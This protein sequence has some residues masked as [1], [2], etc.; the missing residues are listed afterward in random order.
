MNRDGLYL[1]HIG[2]CIDK[3]EQ[4]TAGGRPNSSGTQ[5]T[6]DAVLRNL[7][8]MAESSKRL[9]PRSRLHTRRSIGRGS[10]T[11]ATCWFTT[12]WG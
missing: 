9:S 2:E 5:K 4:Y 10:R 11:S 3:I 6:Q 8:T 1:V 7:Q 12:T